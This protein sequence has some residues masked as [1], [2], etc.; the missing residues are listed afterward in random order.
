M[1]SLKLTIIV[2]ALAAFAIQTECIEPQGTYEELEQKYAMLVESFNKLKA[3]CKKETKKSTAQV[4]GTYEE[5]E[6]QYAM[7]VESFDKLE[8]QRKL[9]EAKNPSRD[10]MAKL[11][12]EI[13]QK[14]EQA[15]KLYSKMGEFP[16]FST[17]E[18]E[19]IPASPKY[20]PTSKEYK[21]CILKSKE[22]NKDV[23]KLT[24]TVSK[25]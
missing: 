18:G 9:Y 21:A 22:L 25:K 13:A 15:D 23:K 2:L 4:K 8:A 12:I 19:T 10:E 14:R 24:K 17:F 11:D 6:Q 7:L 16:Q 5:L 1:K 20:M 3:E